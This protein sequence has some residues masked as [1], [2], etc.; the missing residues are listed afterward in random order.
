VL[1]VVLDQPLTE[2]KALL[3]QGSRL[4]ETLF[5]GSGEFWQVAQLAALGQLGYA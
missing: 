2:D 4:L 3:Q 1:E 5:V